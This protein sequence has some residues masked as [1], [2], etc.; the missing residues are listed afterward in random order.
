MEPDSSRCAKILLYLKISIKW[1]SALQRRAS[2]ILR[3]KCKVHELGFVT[4]AT[5]PLHLCYNSENINTHIHTKEAP[6]PPS[7]PPAARAVWSD[8][9]GMLD[10]TSVRS[11]KC[12]NWVCSTEED[13]KFKLGRF[14]LGCCHLYDSYNY[15]MCQPLQYSPTYRNYKGNAAAH[16]HGLFRFNPYLSV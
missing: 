2:L 5:G 3:W 10:A 15:T 12:C 8:N 16:F 6:L 14:V 11:E 13:L 4:A 7:P 9:S 1:G